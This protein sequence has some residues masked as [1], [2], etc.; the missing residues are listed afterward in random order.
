MSSDRICSSQ[1]TSPATIQPLLEVS[2]LSISP[3]R[4]PLAP[5][6]LNQV[7]LQ[8]HAQEVLGIFGESGAGK[9]TLAMAIAGSL[10][11]SEWTLEGNISVSDLRRNNQNS[12]NEK[13][14]QTH[15]RVFLSR[16]KCF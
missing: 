7:S 4:T 14:S 5:P 13:C 15:L 6:V 1:S 9:S 11:K 10:P 8:L 2:K 16:S 12:R 3:V